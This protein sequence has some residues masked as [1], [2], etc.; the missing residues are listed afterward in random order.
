VRLHEARRDRIADER[1]DVGI[2]CV[3]ARGGVAVAAVKTHDAP[4]QRRRL[5]ECV[6][7]RRR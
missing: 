1:E 6:R 4:D 2:V 3:A 7:D 5:R